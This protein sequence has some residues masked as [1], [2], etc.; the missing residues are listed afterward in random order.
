MENIIIG[1]TGASGALYAQRLLQILSKLE[2]HVHLAISD[3][4]ALVIKHELGVDFNGIY[5]NSALFSECFMDNITCYN[6]SDMGATIASGCYPVKSMI[7]IPCSMNTLCSIAHGI[8]NNL[9]QRAAGITIK[10]GRKLTV[11][12][13]ETPLSPIHLE[14]MLKLSSA[15]ACILPAMPGF[16]HHPKTIEDQVNFVVA[17]ILDV[18]CIPHTLIPEWH[19]EAYIQEERCMNPLYSQ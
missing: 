7:I 19:G 2:Y 12:P 16:Y 3:A 5:P 6:N 15:G 17:K 14:A 10:E 13:R 9:I 18:L 4:A 1:I 8:S 11:V